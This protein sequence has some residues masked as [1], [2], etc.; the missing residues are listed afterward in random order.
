VANGTC[1]QC[2]GDAQCPSGYLCGGDQQCHAGCTISNQ[3]GGQ[4]PVCDTAT[5]ACVACRAN[6]DCSAVAPLC[7]PTGLC[8]QCETAANCTA[9]FPFCEGGQC[10]ACAND[11][12]CPTGQKCHGGTCR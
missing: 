3:C 8:V 1:V 11:Q 4:R 5:G 12:G 6:T 9:P 10:V 7:N 2:L